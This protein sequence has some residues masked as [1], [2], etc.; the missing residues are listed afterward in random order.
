[1]SVSV[2]CPFR[3]SSLTPTVFGLSLCKGSERLTKQV[4][5]RYKLGVDSAKVTQHQSDGINIVVKCWMGKGK[6]KYSA[7]KKG[8]SNV[9][10]GKLCDIVNK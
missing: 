5:N 7:I 2:L 9:N 4:H 6:G 3:R 1:M 8:K 10:S